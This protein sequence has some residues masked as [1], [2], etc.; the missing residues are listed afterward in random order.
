MTEEGKKE[1]PDGVHLAEDFGQELARVI[2]IPRLR[3]KYFDVLCE[4]Q[5]T[6]CRSQDNELI[7]K[8]CQVNS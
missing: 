1:R 5:E 7:L 8:K 6:G 3:D 2:L 4:M